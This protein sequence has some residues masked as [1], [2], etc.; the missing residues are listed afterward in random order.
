MAKSSLEI[1]GLSF[2]QQFGD[3]YVA[4]FELGADVGCS[5]NIDASDES[6]QETIQ[7]KVTLHVLFWDASAA[8]SDSSQS[9][10]SSFRME[11]AGYNTLLQHHDAFEC[12]QNAASEAIQNVRKFATVY[13]DQAGSA[14]LSVKNKLTELGL[15]GKTTLSREECDRLVGSGLVTGLVLLPYAK[16]PAVTL[17]RE[18]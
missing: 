2:G 3:Y 5:L 10:A 13:M 18:V 12:P 9:A 7:V 6:Q 17:A 16:L 4:G 1:G 14:R 11:F 15:E 8:W